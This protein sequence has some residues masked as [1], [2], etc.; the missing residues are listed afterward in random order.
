MIWVVLIVDLGV[1]VAACDFGVDF[2]SGRTTAPSP[3]S[4]FVSMGAVTD[5]ALLAGGRAPAVA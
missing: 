3:K 1:R 5:E 2:A 4:L